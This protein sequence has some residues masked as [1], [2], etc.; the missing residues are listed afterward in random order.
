MMSGIIAQSRINCL[1]TDVV[2][3]RRR[4]VGRLG[5]STRKVVGILA[6]QIDALLGWVPL[7]PF[8]AIA[9]A[10]LVATIRSNSGL[11]VDLIIQSVALGGLA[12]CLTDV[13]AVLVTGICMRFATFRRSPDEPLELET[14]SPTLT[15]L[16]LGLS[17]DTNSDPLRPVL[18][19]T[20]S[21]LPCYR[22]LPLFSG[23]FSVFTS[24]S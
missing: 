21:M 5:Q 9:I 6:S 11:R 14:F 19:P 13:L 22:F 24:A 16:R 8:G 15:G 18:I 3:D 7:T 12:I 10:A 23:P 20:P 4:V 2:G 1:A 17:G